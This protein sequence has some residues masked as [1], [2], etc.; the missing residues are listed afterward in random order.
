[1]KAS[2]DEK[3]QITGIMRKYYYYEEQLPLL[4]DLQV[5]RLSRGRHRG[6]GDCLWWSSPTP[7]HM[8]HLDVRWFRRRRGKMYSSGII[9][10]FGRHPPGLCGPWIIF[11]GFRESEL[12]TCLADPQFCLLTLDVD[13]HFQ[14]LRLCLSDTELCRLT[15]DFVSCFLE[16]RAS[17]CGLC[18]LQPQDSGCGTM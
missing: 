6:Q 8:E 11:P 4:S 14:N 3:L 10:C 7:H 12:W 17:I 13:L 15:L 5:R 1:M 16:P 2:D 9:V 18:L